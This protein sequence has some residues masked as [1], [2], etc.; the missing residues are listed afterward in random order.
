MAGA[1]D[2]EA[3]AR[4][5][6][7]NG[8]FHALIVEAAHNLAVSAALGLNDKIP[9]VSPGTVVF[10]KAAQ[11]RRFMMLSYAHRQHHAIIGALVNGE[12][13]RVE[14]LMNEHTHI[15]M[16]SLNLPVDGPHLSAGGDTAAVGTVATVAA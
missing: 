15:S 11:Q 1:L 16:E 8:R 4:Y 6:A 14:A 9:F 10:D 5:A 2:S 12:G 3:E 7:M 13:A